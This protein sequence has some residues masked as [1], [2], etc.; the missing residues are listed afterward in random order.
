MNASHLRF[1]LRIPF[2]NLLVI[3]AIGVVLR[4]KIVFSL[5]FVDQKYLLHAHSHFAFAGWLT[6]LIMAYMVQA[7]LQANPLADIKRFR[8]LLSVN[9]VAAYGMLF[10]FPFQGYGPVSISFS[11]LSVLVSWWFALAVWKA[12]NRQD[13]KHISHAWFKAAVSFNAV[14]AMG[15]F[16]L[17]Y[18]MWAKMVQQ[19][20]YLAAIYYFLHFQYN[21]WFFFAA[22]GLLIH[23]LKQVQLEVPKAMSV[24]MFRLFFFAAIPAYFLSALWLPMPQ[25]LYVIVVVAALAQVV[26]LAAFLTFIRKNRSLLAAKLPA[27]VQWLWMLSLIAFS[28][29][30]LLQAGSTIPALNTVAYGFRPIVIGYLH[31]VLLG[32]LSLFMIGYYFTGIREKPG[33]QLRTGLIVFVSGIILNELLLLVQGSASMGYIAIPFIGECLLAA[34]CIMFTGMVFTVAGI[35][36]LQV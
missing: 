20:L 27:T 4:Y 29:K 14:S 25:W 22:M 11:T 30:I 3:A 24:Y 35:R 16:A 1:W 19:E 13:V 36:R 31:L 10:S 15:A 23:Y 17:G 32:V 26:G 9:L 5:P 18:M 12:L 34:A 33:K 6:Q 28:I 8:L 7:L 2:Y 21:G